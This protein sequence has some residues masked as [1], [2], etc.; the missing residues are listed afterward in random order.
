MLVATCNG[1]CVQ[2]DLSVPQGREEL[3]GKH[4][5]TDVLCEKQACV[6]AM[7]QVPQPVHP[8]WT[9][10]KMV[11]SVM[12]VPVVL[13]ASVCGVCLMN[14]GR[15]RPKML[16]VSQWVG[17]VVKSEGAKAWGF[18]RWGGEG[19]GVDWVGGGDGD[20]E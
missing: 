8:C 19:E 15:S 18:A 2:V 10:C 6:M 7:C 20:G 9:V 4:G 14:R 12:G 16:Q 5:L 13:F 3:A 1:R 11:R 17:D